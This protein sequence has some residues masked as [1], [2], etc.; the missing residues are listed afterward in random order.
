MDIPH[1]FSSILYGF[2]FVA[3]IGI[4]F[5]LAYSISSSLDLNFHSLK[6]AII[7][8]SGARYLKLNSNLTWSFPFPVQPW[9]TA[10]ALSFLTIF[11]ILS[12]INGLDKE[13]AI[14]YLS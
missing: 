9:A 4:L 5:F 8:S 10:S 3:G 13:V 11:T 6:G 7:L 14:G 1:K 2:S 12:A